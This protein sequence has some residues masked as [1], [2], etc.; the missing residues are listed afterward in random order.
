MRGIK[1]VCIVSRSYKFVQF[2]TK[3]SF[4]RP[5]G[6]E[7]ARRI[8]KLSPESKLLFLSQES[9]ADVVQEILH[10]GALGYVAKRR[11]GVDLLAAVEAICQ[12]TRF[13]SPG[14]LGDVPVGLGD[15]QASN[16]LQPCFASQPETR[17]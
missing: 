8:R 3:P 6:I 10:S 13:V 12:G 11:A 1:T 4:V 2:E 14:L 15:R 5:T 16:R 9:S 17:D 7:A